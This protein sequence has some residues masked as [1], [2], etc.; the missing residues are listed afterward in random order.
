VDAGLLGRGEDAGE[1]PTDPPDVLLT[2]L[3]VA[4]GDPDADWTTLHESDDAAVRALSLRWRP[5]RSDA[6]DP[7]G[8][9][10]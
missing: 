3:A 6:P 2:D 7:V 9:R 1:R 10:D 5:Y 4:D 8:R